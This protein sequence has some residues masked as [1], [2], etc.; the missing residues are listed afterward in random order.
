MEG[1]N[2]WQKSGCHTMREGAKG[3]VMKAKTPFSPA[4]ILVIVALCLQ[5]QTWAGAGDLIRKIKEKGVLV[6]AQVGAEQPPFF[7]KAEKNGETEWVGYEVDLAKLIADRLEVKLEIL[8]LGD[9]YNEVCEVVRDGKAD[10]GISNLSDTEARRK[11]VDFTKPYIVSRVAMFL[12]LAGLEESGIDA[13]EPADLN[14]PDVK[15]ALT[16]DSA[17]E[18]V[19]EEIMP[20]AARVTSPQGN[21]DN[22]A[23]PVLNA[24]AHL[25]IDDGFTFF[26]GMDSHPEF[27]G[28]YILHVFDEYDD[29]LSMC[30]PLGE[31]EMREFLDGIIDE[32][33]ERE[34]VTLELI[35]DK[36]MK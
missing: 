7:W 8:R 15:A 26:L 3:T 20:R 11:L 17:Y 25:V 4:R 1:F 2:M 32:I 28:R 24:E 33:E 10:I 5:A 29:P 30:L 27:A 14:R 9:D 34:P 12:D 13:I 18:F 31:P 21:F 6:V 22:I 23:G 36:Y 35:V 16:Q 19:H